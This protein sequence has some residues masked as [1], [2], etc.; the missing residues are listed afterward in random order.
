ATAHVRCRPASGWLACRVGTRYIT[1]GMCEEDMEIWDSAGHLVAQ[2]RQLTL[3][4]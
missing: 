2:S 1:G 4:Q 3:L